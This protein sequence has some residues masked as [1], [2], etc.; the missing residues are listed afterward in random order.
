MFLTVSL[1]MVKYVKH[2]L[3][4]KKL[5]G[6]GRFFGEGGGTPKRATHHLSFLLTF[7]LKTCFEREMERA[8]LMT[9]LP[10]LIFSL[11]EQCAPISSLM[12]GTWA[13][14]H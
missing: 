9:A 4:F 8:R 3:I 5:P 11:S 6:H 12:C 7:I 14:L 2:I 1:F 13:M 10:S